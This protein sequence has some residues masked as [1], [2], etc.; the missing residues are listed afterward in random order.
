MASLALHTGPLGKRLAKHL[1]RRASFNMTKARVDA[2]AS[3]TAEAAV[4]DLFTIP[5]L[6]QA[7][8]PRSWVNGEYW[9]SSGNDPE[10]DTNR[11]RRTVKGW[12]IH[13]MLLDPSIRGKM[14][15]FLHACFTANLE[16]AQQ[17][18][19]HYAYIL[20]LQYHAA[21]NF[22]TL[23]KKVTLD[24]RMLDFLDNRYNT[25]NS[26]NENY[27]REFLELFTIQKGALQG[28]GDYTT[29][30]EHDIMMA[31]KVLSGFTYSDSHTDTD[32]GLPMGRARFNQHDLTDKTFSI[33]FEE[34]TITAATSEADMFRELDD[35]VEMVFAQPATATSFVTRLYRF[36]VRE[37]ITPEAEQDIINPLAQDLLNSD[38]DIAPVLKKLLKSQH[39]FDADDTDQTDEMV[40]SKLKS[41]LELLLQGLSFFELDALIPDPDASLE[42]TELHYHN[43]YYSFAQQGFLN[44]AKMNFLW[45]PSVLGYDAYAQAPGYTNAWFDGTSIVTRYKIINAFF[46][47]RRPTNNGRIFNPN[48][49]LIDLP[50]FVKNTFSNPAVADDLVNEVVDYLL[51]ETLD[52]ARFD[53]FKGLLLGDL[54]AE[55]WTNEWLDYLSTNDGMGVDIQ[56]KS[57]FKGIV[58]SPEYQLL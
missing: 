51:P 11:Q 57:L 21:G 26:P 45:A 2:F 12:C 4:E 17:G 56:L 39:F 46:D 19:V 1:L 25:K 37:E 40:G 36:F 32:T 47:G 24:N 50:N 7:Q 43:F 34:A 33:S 54:S 38:Y 18:W 27:A 20:L 41:P 22:K 35:F 15:L 31:A 13:E 53:Y 55:N 23:A 10:F 3:M 42:E 58:S 6:V 14:V 8:G 52:V 16:Q 9:L 44:A 29:Y 49:F 5:S 28:P 48:T 30:T